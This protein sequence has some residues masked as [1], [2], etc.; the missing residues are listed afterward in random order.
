MV[1]ALDRE[2]AGLNLLANGTGI[3]QFIVQAQDYG[4]PSL[5]STST[6]RPAPGE[7]ILKHIFS[8]LF[9]FICLV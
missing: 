3:Y 7:L 9:F 5:S 2:K 8:L 1:K 4:I 6:V